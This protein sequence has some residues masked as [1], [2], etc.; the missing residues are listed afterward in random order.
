MPFWKIHHPADAYTSTDKKEFS[1]AV[2][3][4]Y[5]GIPIPEF[6]VVVV[7]EEVVADD[8]YVGG[9]PRD[10]FVRINIDQM[11]RTLPGQ[12]IREWWTHNVDAVIQ[13]WVGA[14]GYDWEFT[15]AEPPADL[16]SL[17]GEI[18]PP[19]ESVAEQRWIAENAASPYTQAEK[20]PVHLT[21]TPGTRG[22][23]TA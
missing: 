16:W 19:F 23:G 18:P 4:L 22:D 5:K 14:R 8:F 10:N 15:I 20:I 17:Q 13:P 6:Y 7:F 11:A 1:A 21:L 9:E 12:I 2:T 3:Q